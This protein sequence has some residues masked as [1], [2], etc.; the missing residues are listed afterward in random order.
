MN[1]NRIIIISI[2]KELITQTIKSS[3]LSL[4]MIPKK[5]GMHL[6]GLL[7]VKSG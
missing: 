5:L 7:Q 3:N 2:R 1:K 4:V 6:R